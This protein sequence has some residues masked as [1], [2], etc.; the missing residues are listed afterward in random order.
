MWP[1]SSL[2]ISRNPAANNALERTLSRTMRLLQVLPFLYFAHAVPAAADCGDM[3]KRL[4][5]VELGGSRTYLRQQPSG[6]SLSPMTQDWKVAGI[7]T[8]SGTAHKIEFAQISVYWHKGRAVSVLA[9]A[10]GATA[11]ALDEALQTISR[12]AS[13]Q[14]THDARSDQFRLPCKDQ[15]GVGAT[16]TKIVRGGGNPDIPVLMLS[17]DHPLKAEMQKDMQGR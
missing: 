7:D 16:K 13:L 4:F 11:A 8:L 12:L 14:F 15:L 1:K 5:G 10:R 3:A 2:T 6:L 9:S 17:I